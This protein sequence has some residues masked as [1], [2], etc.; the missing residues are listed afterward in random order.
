MSAIS[1]Q[2]PFCGAPNCVAVA[3]GW[4]RR[5][6]ACRVCLLS[7]NTVHSVPQCG[8]DAVGLCVCVCVCVCVCGFV[9]HRGLVFVTMSDIVCRIYS[10]LRLKLLSC[11]VWHSCST[12]GLLTRSVNYIRGTWLLRALS[13]H[14]SHST[15]AQLNCTYNSYPFVPKTHPF[16]TKNTVLSCIKWLSPYYSKDLH[17][18]L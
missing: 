11:C 15:H 17:Q 18:W 8:D 13:N 9:G 10:L 6:W 1:D 4:Q 12:D 7:L 3:C 16:A 14:C 5:R 2:L